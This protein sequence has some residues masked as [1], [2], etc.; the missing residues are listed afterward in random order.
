MFAESNQIDKSSKVCRAASNINTYG[1]YLNI[2]ITGKFF[3]D[4]NLDSTG[5]W[6]IVLCNIYGFSLE[7]KANGKEAGTWTLASIRNIFIFLK[8]LPFKLIIC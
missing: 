6:I 5:F 2:L 1:N 7:M 4:F 3:N 8:L